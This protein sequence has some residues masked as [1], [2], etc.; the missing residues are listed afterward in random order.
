MTI[1][2][3]ITKQNKNTVIFEYV[4]IWA[5]I[6]SKCFYEYLVVSSFKKRGERDEKGGR[7]LFLLI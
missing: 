2:F 7:Q 4:I 1:L 5:L 6:C 3:L